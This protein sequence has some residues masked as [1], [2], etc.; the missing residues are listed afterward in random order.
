M[1]GPRILRELRAA[2]YDGHRSA[3][4]RVLAKLKAETP[5]SKV[6]ERFETPPGQQARFDWSPYTI[7][8][9]GELRA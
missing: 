7:E 5:S 6:T 4:Y 9:G 2:G 3:V 8:L 1:I